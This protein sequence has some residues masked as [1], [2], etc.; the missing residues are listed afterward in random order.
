MKQPPD[1]VINIM[2]LSFPG[3]TK[4][5]LI[6]APLNDM[7]LLWLLWCTGSLVLLDNN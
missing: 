7:H 2:F 4:K 1:L 6:R 5:C 3:V